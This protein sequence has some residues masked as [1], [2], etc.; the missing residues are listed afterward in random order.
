MKREKREFNINAAPTLQEREGKKYIQGIIPYN[1]PSEWMGFVEYFSPSAFNKTLAD[2][3]DVKALRNHDSCQI[4]GRTKNG[5]LRLQNT[6]TGL[7]CEVEVD[8]RVSYAADLWAAIQRDDVDGMS[9]LFIPIQEEWEHKD[10]GDIRRVTEARLVE[11][12]FGVVFPAYPESTSEAVERSLEGILGKEKPDD[13]DLAQLKNYKAQIDEALTRNAPP[14]P[15]PPAST[16][17]DTME[18]VM[19]ADIDLALAN[20]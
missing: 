4:L 16:Q 12:S 18:L 20:L 10:E 11:V 2:G 17:A 7:L 1:S 6:D 5:A 14:P 3:S 13:E 15:E 9:F 19:D 8:E